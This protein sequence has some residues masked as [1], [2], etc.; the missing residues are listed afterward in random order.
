[1]HHI[2]YIYTLC[3]YTYVKIYLFKEINGKVQE[4]TNKHFGQQRVP[5]NFQFVFFF[6]E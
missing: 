4:K 3:V 2:L 6:Y 5:A 1:M